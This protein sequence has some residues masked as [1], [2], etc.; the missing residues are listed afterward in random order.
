MNRLVNRNYHFSINLKSEVG[1]DDLNESEQ[2]E[3]EHFKEQFL[4]KK[5]FKLA[6]KRFRF[7]KRYSFITNDN[8]FQIDLTIVK[9]SDGFSFIG[10]KLIDTESINYEIE[11]EPSIGDKF[12]KNSS[13]SDKKVD[14]VKLN[15]RKDYWTYFT[16]Y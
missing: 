2:I 14:Y 7:K 10:S 11:L 3:N 5:Q 8:L 6:N 1:C 12:A 4:N 15:L 16:S 13:D 9:Q